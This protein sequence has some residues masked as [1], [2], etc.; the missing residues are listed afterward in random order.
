MGFFS[1]IGDIVE[2]VFVPFSDEIQDAADDLTGKSAERAA[3]AAAAAQEQAALDAIQQEI[4]QRS[5][6]Q[7]F[8]EP[9]SG[10]G[11]M[12]LDQASFLTD[13]Q[14]QFDYLQNNPLFDLALE[15]ANRATLQGAAAGG[16]L[17]SGDTLTGLSNNVLLSAQPLINQQSSNIAGLLDFGLGTA[18]TQGNIA[19]GQGTNVGNLLTDIGDIQ[20]AG[21]VGG[22]NAGISGTQNIANTAAQIAAMFSDVSLKENIKHVGTKNGF[23]WYKW[24]WNDKALELGLSGSSEGV[25]AN[26]VEITRPDLVTTEK[27]Y[28]KVN[29][30][31]VLNG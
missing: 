8:L 20:A 6:A 29:Y 13:P 14:Q 9:Y 25:L 31:G 19:I 2:D 23:N 5:I 1:E 15:N 18:Q 21:I 27:G 12:G 28:K 24:D 3:A 4:E 16:R 22:A 30:Q 11:L 7:G 26:E 10:V 17:A